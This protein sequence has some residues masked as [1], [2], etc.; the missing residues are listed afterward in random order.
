MTS[1]QVHLRTVRLKAV[2]IASVVDCWVHSGQTSFKSSFSHMLI[3]DQSLPLSLVYRTGLL[4]TGVVWY[5]LLVRAWLGPTWNESTSGGYPLLHHPPLGMHYQIGTMPK[6]LWQFYEH[7]NGAQL[8]L[9]WSVSTHP[10]PSDLRAYTKC[11]HLVT[12]SLNNTV[13]CL[14]LR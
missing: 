10:L 13:I 8:L 14:Y 2:Q 9:Y 7:K 4:W 11:F 3:L 12:E 6:I 1:L 5:P